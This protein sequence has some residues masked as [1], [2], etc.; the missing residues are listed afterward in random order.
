MK[1]VNKDCQLL[2]RTKTNKLDLQAYKIDWQLPQLNLIK[3]DKF[4]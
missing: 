1:N 3:K 4:Y 2:M